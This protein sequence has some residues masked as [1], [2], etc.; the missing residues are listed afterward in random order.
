MKNS[1]RTECMMNSEETI[2]MANSKEI[3]CMTNYEGTVGMA[4]SEGKCLAAY[5]VTT[6]MRYSFELQLCGLRMRCYGVPYM[7][8]RQ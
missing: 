7:V 5:H 2:C 4:N 6:L 3:V 8:L 1:E